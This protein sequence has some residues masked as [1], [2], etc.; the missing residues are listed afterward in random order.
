MAGATLAVMSP[1]VVPVD[2]GGSTT[3]EMASSGSEFDPDSRGWRLSA[4]EASTTVGTVVADASAV[5][6]GVE[7]GVDSDHAWEE[8]RMGWG[9]GDDWREDLE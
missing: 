5:R 8:I 1:E 9:T 3:E 4:G 2:E 7:G 6:E